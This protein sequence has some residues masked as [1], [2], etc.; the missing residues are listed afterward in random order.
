MRRTTWTALLWLTAVAAPGQ[1]PTSEVERLAWLEGRWQGVSGGV[2]ME[3]QWTSVRG[4]ALLGLHR[5]VKS[6]RMVSF[7]FLRIQS[8]PEGTVYFASP[9]SRPPV[10]FK[11]KELDE[12][13]AVFENPQHDFPQRILYWLDAN[14]A[15]HARIEGPQGGKTVSEEWVWTKAR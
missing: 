9:G 1:A 8:P 2:E 10:A 6:G 15:M 3:E 7:E 5:D 11:L 4:G 12:R 13:R 14:G